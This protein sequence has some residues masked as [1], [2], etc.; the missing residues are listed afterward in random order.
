VLAAL[1]VAAQALDALR[2]RAGQRRP[3]ARFTRLWLA[4]ADHARRAY[5]G[6]EL[7]EGWLAAG[8]PPGSSGVLAHVG[9]IGLACAPG[10]GGLIA[11]AVRGAHAATEPRASAGECSCDRPPA[12]SR[13]PRPYSSLRPIPS[14]ASS[15][16][17]V[18][19]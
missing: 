1:F 5:C 2:R 17:A 16:V 18:R 10:V 7:I 19:H 13:L 11:L 9:W 8:H 4:C 3:N 6:Q 15:P 12:G 14:R